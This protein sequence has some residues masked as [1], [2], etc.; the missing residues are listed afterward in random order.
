M[1]ETKLFNGKQWSFIKKHF[2]LTL[3]ELE[4]AKLVSCGLRNWRI[5]D[6]LEIRL[7]TVKTHIKNIYRKI[8]ADSKIN[9]LLKFAGYLQ[10]LKKRGNDIDSGEK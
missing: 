8:K 7:G 3:R 5:A 1:S 4:V 9:M 6:K 10:N 2:D